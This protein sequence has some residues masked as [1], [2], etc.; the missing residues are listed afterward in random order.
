MSSTAWGIAVERGAPK[1]PGAPKWLCWS[2][3]ECQ[4]AIREAG[5]INSCGTTC[6]IMSKSKQ[7]ALRSF[8]PMQVMLVGASVGGVVD[9][10]VH[11]V[12]TD[13]QI[14]YTWAQT[15]VSL[16][17]SCPCR[18]PC[19]CNW[20]LAA[21]GAFERFSAGAF[22]GDEVTTAVFCE[23]AANSSQ[24]LQEATWVQGGGGQGG[25]TRVGAI[26]AQPPP[27]FG[28]EPPAAYA[29]AL[30]ALQALP[31][32]RG[33]RPPGWMATM[34]MPNS[35]ATAALIE[36]GRRGMLVDLNVPVAGEPVPATEVG[37][38]PSPGLALAIVRSAPETE[39]VIEHMGGAR[40]VDGNATELAAWVQ[41][42][43]ALAKEKNVRCLQLGG[44]ISQAR[45]SLAMPHVALV[46]GTP[47]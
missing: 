30:D 28:L 44:I 47:S 9:T 5:S 8:L 16:N 19:L 41:G 6:A 43:F 31:L 36:L 4:S 38:P 2:L 13:N 24:W 37:A 35:T 11:I 21:G 33:V 39:F 1:C 27:G 12:T 25:K 46:Q 23:V 45:Q 26:V 7:H 40:P 20:T 29:A 10:H 22:D 18:P 34:T 42:I 15:P 14:G 32:V 3:P 17:E